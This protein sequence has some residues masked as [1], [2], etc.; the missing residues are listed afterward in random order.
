[1]CGLVSHDGGYLREVMILQEGHHASPISAANR[2]AACFWS[3]GMT[4]ARRRPGVR[5][6]LR[7]PAA[8]RRPLPAHPPTAAGSHACAADREP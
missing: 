5:V 2:L 1:M 7:G 4:C 6:M 8:R 3:P